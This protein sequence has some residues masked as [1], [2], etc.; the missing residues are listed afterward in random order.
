MQGL[1][2]V[3]LALIGTLVLVTFL[4]MQVVGV[5]AATNYQDTE[6]HRVEA[7]IASGTVAFDAQ[8]NRSLA[9]GTPKA[10][11]DPIVAQEKALQA[12]PAP[13]NSFFVDKARLDALNQ[14]LAELERLTTGVA[15][16][17]DPGRS[18]AA[19]AAG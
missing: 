7:A 2:S 14:H 3:R 6:S 5:V 15:A 17:R 8:V 9:E 19:P 12:K 18:P 10:L 1:V 13:N 16:D 11:T 4:A